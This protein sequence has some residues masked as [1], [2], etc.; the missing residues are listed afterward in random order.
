MFLVGA[1]VL[2]AA[3]CVTALVPPPVSAPP[4]DPTVRLVSVA[5]GSRLAVTELHRRGPRA[6]APIVV[7]HGGPGVP[8]LRA[9]VAALSPLTERGFDVY[10][11]AQVGTGASTRLADPRGYGVGRDAA[12]LD[13]LDH[14]LGLGQMVLVA[15][16]YGAAVAARYLT[17]HPDRVAA[18]VLI[19][20]QP[21]DPAD[22]SPAGVTARLPLADRL[23]LYAQLIAP[24]ALLGYG[25]LQ[26]A[27]AAAHA[28]LP[29]AEADARNDAL[30]QTSE[31]TL[32]CPGAP[33]VPPVRGTG[34]YAMQFPQSA[35]ARPPDLRP[36]LT[37]LPT[38]TLIVKGSCDYLSWRSAI[39]Y[40]TRL[41]NATLLYLP[42][43]GHNAHQD[44]PEAVR[45]E[46][47]AFLTHQ[48]L[49]LPGYSAS[50]AP[51]GYQ[52]PP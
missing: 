9:N 23:G 42:G 22:N 19:S 26:I 15:H 34:F 20:P 11:Y 52:G 5:T 1:A 25:L 29:D 6:G 30:V 17:T 8:D 45:G 33:A 16:S 12:D 10:L 4:P 46:I 47:T 48:P 36:A 21:L 13:G 38:P 14:A 24:R 35:T 32:H 50:A 51:T 49:P 3:F 41:P 7:L 28:Y 37:G 44:K 39:D 18:M 2:V 31:P 40:R 27:P 43:A